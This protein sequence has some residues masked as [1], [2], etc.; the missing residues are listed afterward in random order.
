MN[1]LQ[2]QA[3]NKIRDYAPDGAMSYQDYRQ[4]MSWCFHLGK[5]ESKTLLNELKELGL[6]KLG[7]HGFKILAVDDG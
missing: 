4:L 5:P 3:I 7:F 2:Q 6:I 1:V